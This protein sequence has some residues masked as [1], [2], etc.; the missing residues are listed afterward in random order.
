MT[1][2]SGGPIT[3]KPSS[4]PTTK[5][6]GQ[7]DQ[8][9]PSTSTPTTPSLRRHPKTSAPPSTLTSPPSQ[10]VPNPRSN[11]PTSSRSPMVPNNRGKLKDGGTMDLRP[12]PQQGRRRRSFHVSNNERMGKSFNT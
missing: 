11:S 6:D 12:G 8:K 2:P 3:N 9:S 1:R 4:S 7:T 10:A 5:D